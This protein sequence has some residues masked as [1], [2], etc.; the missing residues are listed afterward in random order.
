MSSSKHP[1][2][3]DPVFPHQQFPDRRGKIV[4]PHCVCLF[5]QHLPQPYRLWLWGFYPL[6]QLSLLRFQDRESQVSKIWAGKHWLELPRLYVTVVHSQSVIY[7]KYKIHFFPTFSLMLAL[8]QLPLF[9]RERN[10][11]PC[12]RDLESI[13]KDQPFLCSCSLV[14][15]RKPHQVHF[16]LKEKQKKS[17]LHMTV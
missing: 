9:G 8:D 15:G 5:H 1:S 14:K 13:K 12:E 2:P 3:S 10:P 7:T 11:S 16:R 6:L 17:A 4:F